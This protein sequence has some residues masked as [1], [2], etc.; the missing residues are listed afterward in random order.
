MRKM[1]EKLGNIARQNAVF[2]RA[3]LAALLVVLLVSQTVPTE[4]LATGMET[5]AEGVSTTLSQPEEE[6]EGDESA[7]DESTTDEVSDESA[8]DDTAASEETSVESGDE[9]DD[10]STDATTDAGDEADN[11]SADANIDAGDADSDS[12]DEEPALTTDPSAT[13]EGENDLVSVTVEGTATESEDAA[14]NAL[15]A[16]TSL[17]TED[18]RELASTLFSAGDKEMS[19]ATKDGEDL[20]KGDD[21]N[22][23]DYLEVS[24]VTKDTEDNGDDDLLYIKPSDDSDQTVRMR[25][26]YGLSGQHDYEP[27]DITITIP[28]YIFLNRYDGAEGSMRLS[29][30]EDPSTRA[31]WN[32]KIVEDTYVITNTRSMSAA[33]Q[34][35]MEFAIDGIVPHEMVDREKSNPFNAKIEVVTHLGNLIGSMSK[36]ITA[37]FDTEARVTEATIRPYSAIDRVPASEIPEAQRV[38]GVNS[39]V[40]VTWYMNGYVPAST[41]QTYTLSYTFKK[42]DNYNGFVIDRSGTTSSRPTSTDVVIA[43]DSYATGTT[44]YT[45]VEVAYPFN[46]QFAAGKDHT[47]SGSVTYKLTETDPA[48]GTDPKLVTWATKSDSDSWRYEAPE[49]IEPTGHYNIFTYGNSN[50]PYG[51]G[52]ESL[53]VDE[54]AKKWTSTDIN[55]TINGWTGYS[56]KNGYYG[57]YPSALNDLKKDRDVVVSYTSNTVGFLLPWTY[58][59]PANPNEHSL[60]DLNN[61]GKHNITMTSEDKGLSLNDTGN[62]GLNDGS[63]VLGRDYV[64]DSF[65]FARRP[66]VM[67]AQAINLNPDGSVDFDAADDGTVDY[68][69][70]NEAQTPDVTLEVKLNGSWQRYATAHWDQSGAL[71]VTLASGGTQSDGTVSLPQGTQGVR[72]KVTTNAAGV[73]YHTRVDFR[74]L[75]SGAVG[76]LADSA[77]DGSYNPQR[78]I[79]NYSNM[80]A[81]SDEDGN[82]EQIVNINKRGYDRLEG[83]TSDIKAIPSK[84]GEVTNYDDANR[85]ATVSYTAQVELQSFI[86]DET[87]HEQ[88]IK[89]GDLQ[90][91]TSGTWYD[92]LPVGAA[93]VLSSVRLREADSIKSMYTIENYENSGRT[94]LVVEADL[95]PVTD[96]TGT[97]T[98]PDAFY[99]DILELTFDATIDYSIIAEYGEQIHNVVAY[100]SGNTSIGTIERY[101]G[102]SGPWGNNNAA[103]GEAFEKGSTEQ[104]LLGTLE[105][106]GSGNENWLYAGCYTNLAP[107]ETAWGSISKQVSV[108]NDNRWTQGIEYDNDETLARDVYVGANYGYRLTMYSGENS[109]TSNMVVYDVLDAYVPDEENEPNDY[110]KPRWRGTLV[111]V[112][113]SALEAAGCDPTVYYSTIENLELD[114]GAEGNEMAPNGNQEL[115]AK[116]DGQPVWHELTDETDLSKVTAIAIDASK[117]Q[118]GGDFILEPDTMISAYVHMKAPE[119]DEAAPLVKDDAHAYNNVYLASVNTQAGSA[120]GVDNFIRY[121]Y[122]KVGLVNYQ[123]DVKKVWDDGDNRDGKRPDSVTVRLY[124]DG[125]PA[126][127]KF[128]E[129]ISNDTLTLNEGNDWYGSFG[130]LPY[131]HDDGTKIIYTLQ[132][133][134]TLPDGYHPNAIFDGNTFTLTNVYEPETTEVSGSK[135]W[136]G[137]T[138]GE[139]PRSVKVNLYANGEYYASQTV[140]ADIDGTW[141]YT[142]T[143]LPKYYDSGKPIV[144]T[145]EEDVASAPS[146]EHGQGD[147]YDLVNN[148]HPYGD[149]K[150]SKSVEDVTEASRNKT[151]E[152]TFTFTREAPSGETPVF[153]RFAYTIYDATTNEPVE[154]GTGTVTTSETISLKGGQYVLITE[155][156][157]DVHYRVVEGSTPGFSAS[158]SEQTGTIEPNET[159]EEEFTNTYSAS[160]R[161][162]LQALKVLTGRDLLAYQFRFELV[163]DET[164][165]VVRTAGNASG[166]DTTTD[167]EGNVVEDGVVTF[168]AITYTQADHGKTFN[169]T[170]QET[171]SQRPGYTYTDVIYH[172]A[173][174]P[175]DT[176]DGTMRYDIVYTDDEGH[177]IDD[178]LADNGVVF[179]NTYKSDG[180][181][182]I[183][184]HKT[185]IGGELKDG[186]FTFEIDRVVTEAGKTTLEKVGTGTNDADGNVT[187]DPIKYDQRDNDQS[188][189]YV[190]REVQSGSGSVIYDGHYAL[191]RANVTDNGDGT[192]SVQTDFDV[193]EECWEC[194]GDG[195][196][197]S[198][199]DCKAC[200]GTGTI[201]SDASSLMFENYGQPGDLDIQKTVSN[202]EEADPEQTFTFRVE[203]TNND[204]QAVDVGPG[205]PGGISVSV[206][207]MPGTA[208]HAEAEADEAEQPEAAANVAAAA[209]E[210]AAEAEDASVEADADTDEPVVQAAA[211]DEVSANKSAAARAVTLGSG[212]VGSQGG[213]WKVDANGVLTLSGKDIYIASSAS[214]SPWLTNY[215]DQITS[216]KFTSGSSGDVYPNAMKAYTSLESVNFT[217]FTMESYFRVTRMFMG[218]DSLKSVD[219][220]TTGSKFDERDLD[221]SQMFQGCSSLESVDFGTNFDTSGITRMSSLFDGCANLKSITF[222]PKFDT[223]NVTNMASMF[224]GCS[225]LTSITFPSAFSTAKVTNMA[226]MFSG[227]SGLTSLDLSGLDTSSVTNMANMF[228]GCSGLTSLDLSGSFDTSSVTNMGYMFNDCSGLTSLD[229]SGLDTSSVTNMANMFYG[230]S[231]LTSL[232]LSGS[233]DTSSVTNMGYMFN[234]CSGLTSLDLSGLDTSSVTRMSFIFYGCDSLNSVTLG[235]DFEF[236]GT[237][238]PYVLPTPPTAKGTW[239]NV[240]SDGSPAEGADSLTPAQLAMNYPGPGCAAGTY[241]WDTFIDIVFDGNGSMGGSMTNMTGVNAA[242][243]VTLVRNGFV[244][245]GYRFVGWSTTPKGE[246][247]Y[248]NGATI[249]AADLAD[250]TTLTLYAQWESVIDVRYPEDGV[251]EITMPANFHALIENLPAGTSYRVYE[252]TP[253]GWT[254]KDSSN[255][256]G[257]IETNETQVAK[258]VN[259]YTPTST[260]VQ[261]TAT[262]TLDGQ[263]ANASD[264]FSFQLYNATYTGATGSTPIQT[265]QVTNGGNAVF[266]PLTFNKKGTYYYEIRES[267]GSDASVTYDATRYLA[268]VT[269]KKQADGTLS[270]SVEYKRK[271]P[272]STSFIKFDGTA[273][274]FNNTTKAG[275]LSITKT[276][277]GALS[278][279]TASQQFT[280]Q[281]TLGGVPYS[282]NYTVGPETRKTSDGRITLAADETAT[283]S[284]QPAGTSYQVQEIEVP[285]GWQLKGTTGNLSGAITANSTV[286][287]T[288]T[289]E[290]ATSG[291]VQLM[292]YKQLEGGTVEDGQ[293]EFELLDSTGKV[294][295]TVKNGPVDT[296]ET[297]PNPD[298]TGTGAASEVDNPAY[299]LA[300]VYFSTLTFDEETTET[301]TIREKIPADAEETESGVWVKDGIVYDGSTWT[302]TVKMKDNGQGAL[303][304]T[305]TY[306]KDNEPANMATFT[307]KLEPTSLTVRKSVENGQLSEKAQANATFTFTLSLKDATG[308]S[309]AEP[310]IGQVYNEDGTKVEGGSGTVTVSDGGSFS[311]GAGQYVVFDEVPVGTVYEVTEEEKDGWTQV[312]DKTTNTSGTLG[313]EG[314]EAVVTNAYSARGTATF[315]ATKRYNGSVPEDGQFTFLLVDE[316]E[317]SESEGMLLQSVTNNEFGEIE[318]QPIE[319]TEA[320]DGKTFTYSLYEQNGGE[321][322]ISYDKSVVKVEVTVADN[323][324]GTLDIKTTYDGEADPH[325][326]QNWLA[327]TLARTGGPGVWAASVGTVV[328]ALGCLAYLRRKRERS[329]HDA[330]HTRR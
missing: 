274:V 208:S 202:P 306:A 291:W 327:V 226:S 136:T 172:A 62:G 104:E 312:A 197:S 96:T 295:E 263:W 3:L 258:F 33:T 213:T 11:A 95:T 218:M 75:H 102:E 325:Q 148:Y 277:E 171:D 22:N 252:Q 280:F 97:D 58:E 201:T 59:E 298:H 47:F 216:I 163:N 63:L 120:E 222:S 108:N 287:L 174:T 44:N 267:R 53:Y 250:V 211:S 55:E 284:G 247:V 209:A 51:R 220:G 162:N 224:Y 268:V 73:L 321:E 203:L 85:T 324:D 276:A 193:S 326:F 178:P 289:N 17:N 302:V 161:V 149:L 301:Y 264:G 19:V 307:N 164:G 80:I 315:E 30:P 52:Q 300:P 117:K 283:I 230:C 61:Y 18:A 153:D 319:Y 40:I 10:A 255:T 29:I 181:L 121:D 271:A 38:N 87:T 317:G 103:T 119:S 101:E 57:Y 313:S 14:T 330:K 154:D 261:L 41:N 249:P 37:E 21:A 240:G 279:A 9:A 70:D 173:V 259:E 219:F 245:P 76:N 137:D 177:V 262:K 5:I 158:S 285:A 67:K 125:A 123:I 200:G 225:S 54:A 227:C 233:F 98:D 157:E 256:M 215:A 207:Q 84:E 90:L 242:S 114:N 229:L 269:V 83:Y 198:A 266:S 93:P 106:S 48:N 243:G 105:G 130:T 66:T 39:Y 205:N 32:Y 115:D 135:T 234:D 236:G 133:V 1:R 304:P 147:G 180:Q 25:V 194:G 112:D 79:W 88:A 195:T 228:Y 254:L 15:V 273:P 281:V 188:Y 89:D 100:K 45:L 308:A 128:P 299:G 31:A 146:Y 288:F 187:F 151:F 140:R 190:I 145:V 124:A 310:I 175:Y 217:G 134:S 314:A 290:Y 282:G 7:A 24:W 192:M 99:S 34:G 183:T 286:A 329:L 296:N 107:V 294:I 26:S 186:Q 77:F 160:T 92:L 129:W 110:N 13:Y 253:A 270:A 56:Q 235:P 71:T 199:G 185:L 2:A 278:E 169:Y 78:S 204:G 305:V 206:D 191:V 223:S 81:T 167:D 131:L 328:V 132:E 196:V 237:T 323:G 166:Q 20:P 182:T 297:I 155:I 244:R 150:V 272:G 142:F 82:K 251:I 113:T 60:G 139:R 36:D 179:E 311:L 320:D 176:G 27:G 118:G 238:V 214:L 156:P 16:D 165:E 50:R 64:Y 159:V 6:G 318:F 122:T 111:G 152:F 138:P 23:V 109:E 248:E 49:F 275:R 184:A 246:V 65:D 309:L 292:A 35:F 239:I 68:A 170:I 116:V 189:L 94:L 241:V 74:L 322:N 232:D 141:N 260:S 212:T 28:S 293:F 210:P 86:S 4:A 72:T 316:T 42:T 144:Y 143:D 168:G 126:A 231:G 265:V 257:S 69:V 303:T 46:G 8:P 91:E 127:E 43:E 12:G 221:L